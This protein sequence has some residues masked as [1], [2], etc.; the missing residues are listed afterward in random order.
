MSPVPS[1]N[2]V[3]SQENARKWFWFLLGRATHK[4]AGHDL[5]WYRSPRDLIELHL[6]P[7]H[8][9]PQTRATNTQVTAEAAEIRGA[10]VVWLALC[11]TNSSVNHGMKRRLGWDTRTHKNT[12]C[13]GAPC[14]CVLFRFVASRGHL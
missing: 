9:Q 6:C 2:G 1:K 14:S 5:K 12:P 13:T 3:P 10:R 11:A 4:S 8:R 7:N